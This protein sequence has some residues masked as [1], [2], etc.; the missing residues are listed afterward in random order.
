M[1]R[2]LDQPYANVAAGVGALQHGF[3]QPASNTGVL[4]GR[5]D[6]DRSY[7]CNGIAFPEKVAA[8]DLTVELGDN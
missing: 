1:V 4:S 8:D 2:G 5:Y 7:P 3:H 6:G